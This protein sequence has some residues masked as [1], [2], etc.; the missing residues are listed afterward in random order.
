MT[1]NTPPFSFFKWMA[2]NPDQFNKEELNHIIAHEKAHIKQYHSIDILL[3]QFTAIVLWFNPFIWFYKKALQQNL[4]FIAD[5]NA[6]NTSMCKTS[7][8]HV[9]LKT[10]MPSHQMAL[11]STFYNSS[12]K[13]RIVMLQKSKSKKRNLFKYALILPFLVLFLMGFNTKEVY[14]AKIPKNDNPNQRIASSYVIKKSTSDSQLIAIKS[15]INEKGGAFSYTYSRNDKGEIDDLQFEIKS[16]GTGTFKSEAQFNAVYFGTL[17]GGGIFI[18]EDE[19]HYK[20]ILK[21]EN[22]KQK[23]STPQKQSQLKNN[24]KPIISQNHNKPF[25]VTITKYFTDG[26]FEKVIKKAKAHS[27]ILKF[28]KIKRN[29]QNEII[30]ITTE[31]KVGENKKVF[32]YNDGPIK[33]FTCYRNQKDFGFRNLKDSSKKASSQSYVT[34]IDTIQFCQGLK[35][36]SSDSIHFNKYNISFSGNTKES[37]ATTSG[38]SVFYLSSEGN[39][40]LYIID[41]KEITKDEIDSMNPYD[42]HSVDVLKGNA[43]KVLYGNK[44]KNGVVAIS[45]KKLWKTEFTIG[46]PF[47]STK[48][49]DD[50]TVSGT[51]SSHNGTGLPRTN[52]IV[53][54]TTRGALSDYDGNYAI[55]VAKGETLIFSYK[56]MITQEATVK[57]KGKINITLMESLYNKSDLQNALIIIDG[58]EVHNKTIDDLD[59]NTIES[60]SILK[61][62]KDIKEY[63]EKGKNGVIK[64]TTKK[65]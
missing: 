8:Q 47:G 61:N 32:A 27:V 26:D 60:I 21:Q 7:Y 38:N 31:I 28:S 48:N 37:I 64:I 30:K 56:G 11:T 24:S 43:A 41:G 10:S 5:S 12:I 51:V 49:Q 22:S 20:N 34:K 57:S 15:E 36:L 14:V 65:D 54:G 18:A 52:I 45:T 39:N 35:T 42:I 23:R 62:E 46:H 53:K 19:E 25:S 16:S 29:S 33:P 6:Q 63:G 4:E 40:P 55:K 3:C 58:K 50:F 1:D 17:L 2:Y 13:K 44:A 9:L 59:V